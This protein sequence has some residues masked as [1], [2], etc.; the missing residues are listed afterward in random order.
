MAV[1]SLLDGEINY[2][3]ER[4]LAPVALDLEPE[5]E[6]LNKVNKRVQRSLYIIGKV[7]DEVGESLQVKPLPGLD[8]LNTEP[9]LYVVNNNLANLELSSARFKFA[10]NDLSGAADSAHAAIPG[11]LNLVNKDN[12]ELEPLEIVAKCFSKRTVDDRLDR[13]KREISTMQELANLGEMT[14]VPLAVIM[15]EVD[16]EQQIILLTEYYDGLLTLD[17]SPWGL[18]LTEDNIETA[19]LAAEGLGRFNRLGFR[20]GDAKIKNFGQGIGGE[21]GPIDFET[22]DKINISNPDQ[23][24]GA[25]LFDYSKLIESLNKKGFFGRGDGLPASEIRDALDSMTLAYTDQWR[26]EPDYLQPAVWEST[27]LAIDSTLPGV[28]SHQGYYPGRLPKR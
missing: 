10:Q 27:K 3:D 4:D 8:R 25:I 12:F 2:Q 1:N 6:S 18:G 22:T 17:N 24:R 14:T 16:D 20:H 19:M 21:F 13:V 7:S 5:A 15:A 23:V 28:R 11:Q 9:G 26:E